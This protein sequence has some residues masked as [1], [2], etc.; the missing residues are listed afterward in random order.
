[1]KVSAQFFSRLKDEAGVSELEIQLPNEATVGDLL[2]KLFADFPKLE[3]WDAH[4][5]TAVGVEYVGRDHMLKPDE[6]VAI[7]PPVQGG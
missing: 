4:I 1:M 6:V 7:M 3:K 5:L 2:A